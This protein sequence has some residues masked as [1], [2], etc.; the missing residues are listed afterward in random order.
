M[1]NMIYGL[2]SI[3]EAIKAK[4]KIYKIFVGN[5]IKDDLTFLNDLPQETIIKYV[6]K[7]WIDSKVKGNHQGIIAE[8]EWYKY[9]TLKESLDKVKPDEQPWYIILDSIEDPHNFGAIIRTA[10]SAKVT[11]IIIPKN[12]SV[13]INSTVVKVSSGGIEY[14]DIIKDNVVNAIN[15]LK[16]NGFWIIGTDILG[17]ESYYNLDMSGPIAIVVGNEGKGMKRLVKDSCDFLVKI[18]MLGKANSLNASVS[19]G[20]IIYEALRQRVNK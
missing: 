9:I 7:M 5:Y 19:A 10:E 11:G 20:I 13:E 6:D 1:D 8:V 3:K 4:R 12:R 18:P 17:K 16:D 14:I 2:N 15:Y